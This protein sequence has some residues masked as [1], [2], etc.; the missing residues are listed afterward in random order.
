M[1]TF[2]LPAFGYQAIQLEAGSG[3]SPAHQSLVMG[4]L[5]T[6]AAW[7]ARTSRIPPDKQIRYAEKLAVDLVQRACQDETT[8]RSELARF[9]AKARTFELNASVMRGPINEVGDALVHRR[10]RVEPGD[11]FDFSPPWVA[12]P[13][14]Q[15]AIWS[16]MWTLFALCDQCH[17][18]EAGAELIVDCQHPVCKEAQRGDWYRVCR[19]SGIDPT[20]VRLLHG[21]A[22]QAGW[23]PF[24]GRAVRLEETGRAR[25]DAW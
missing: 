25:E 16:A 2:I 13:E 5:I 9:V 15:D 21:H 24:Q 3:L 12:A 4:H 10:F 1:A 14:L 22:E 8:L 18:I 11:E 23:L 6:T 7:M 19:I 20:I 17:V